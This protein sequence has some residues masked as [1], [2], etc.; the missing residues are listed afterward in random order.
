MGKRQWKREIKEGGKNKGKGSH[1]SEGRGEAREKKGKREA[2]EGG[3]ER[4]EEA[5][6]GEVRENS[7]GRGR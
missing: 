6:K 4:E 5:R 1:V 3:G 7:K 2:R